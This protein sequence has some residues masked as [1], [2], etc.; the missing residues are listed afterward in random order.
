MV[1]TYRTVQWKSEKGRMA[2]N[3]LRPLQYKSVVGSFE[4]VTKTVD[5]LVRLELY[6]GERK[7]TV[8]ANASRGEFS[9]V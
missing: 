5:M 1:V 6:L 7:V 9:S 2:W 8:D 3:R 4:S